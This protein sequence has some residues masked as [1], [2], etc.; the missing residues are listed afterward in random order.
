MAGGFSPSLYPETMRVIIISL[1]TLLLL[2]GAQALE[3]PRAVARFATLD[4]REVNVRTGPGT[5]YPI[6]FILSRDELPVEIV[7]E[8]D[9]WRQIRTEQG[10]EGWVH[11]SLLAARRSVIIKDGP[12]TLLK[13]PHAGATPLVKLETGV[14]ARLDRCDGEWCYLKVAGYKGWVRRGHVWG[15]YKDETFDK[16]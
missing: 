10:D 11:K 9:I 7:K 15:V 6:K 1:L 3:P 12:E 8:F 14:I 4:S 13:K 5:R 2:S 16:D